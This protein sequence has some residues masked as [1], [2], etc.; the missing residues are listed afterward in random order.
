MTELFALSDLNTDFDDE[1]R[2]RDWM[3]G[4][5]LGYER[6][7]K[8]RELIERHLEELTRYG[9][10]PTVGRNRPMAGRNRPTVGRNRPMA[11]RA[12]SS[13]EYWLNEGQALCIATISNAPRSP[14][15]RQALILVFMSWRRGHLPESPAQKSLEIDEDRLPLYLSL[16]REMRLAHGKAAARA[17]WHQ[18]PLPHPEIK[19][20][21][22]KINDEII[23]A[24]LEEC[25]IPSKGAVIRGAALYKAY[26]DWCASNGHMPLTMARFGRICGQMIR[27]DITGNRVR[28]CDFIL[29]N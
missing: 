27:K 13:Q 3:I 7:R 28:Y 16:V 21:S 15:V 8:I 17:L 6:P 19:H 2:I 4:E 18:L 26:V 20:V 25:I 5:R 1:P 24:F 22:K 11:G 10:C 9:V 14:D 23:K 12:S 29:K